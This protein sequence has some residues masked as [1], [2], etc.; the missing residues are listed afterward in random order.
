MTVIS[1]ITAGSGFGDVVVLTIIRS[2]GRAFGDCD[3]QILKGQFQLF[4]LALDLFP[5]L[6]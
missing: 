3:Q 5:R 4:D 1:G 2:T 6:V